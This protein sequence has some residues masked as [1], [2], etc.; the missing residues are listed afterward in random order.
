MPTRLLM[1]KPNRVVSVPLDRT[2]TT[3]SLFAHDRPSAR[4]A[5]K[6]ADLLSRLS[7]CIKHDYTVNWA[8]PLNIRRLST[9]RPF[10]VCIR[11]RNPWTRIL[12]RFFG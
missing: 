11:D 10:L 12:R 2:P 4:V 7:R 6:S 1:E 5:A 9:L 8:R 3:R